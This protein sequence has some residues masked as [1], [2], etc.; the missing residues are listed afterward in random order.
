MNLECLKSVK[1]RVGVK[2]TIKALE[3]DSVALVYIAG[4]ADRQVTAEVIALCLVKDVEIC[5]VASR[6]E[7]GNAC[8]IDVG[9]AVVAV[10]K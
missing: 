2:Q 9:A 7:L 5:P 1:K 6:A 3:K 4:D 10:L 8:G